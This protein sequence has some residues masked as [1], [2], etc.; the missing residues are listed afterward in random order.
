MIAEAALKI[1][2][3]IQAAYNVPVRPSDQQ[4][5]AVCGTKVFRD[6]RDLADV[7]GLDNENVSRS[8][9]RP[10]VTVVP[11]FLNE[12]WASLEIDHPLLDM[13]PLD[14]SDAL[15]AEDVACGPHIPV[16]KLPQDR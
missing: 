15:V 8:K 1:R 9:C 2:A 11:G 14:I 12:V 3:Q 4:C 7:T 5:V 13:Q 10:W 6:H 16:G